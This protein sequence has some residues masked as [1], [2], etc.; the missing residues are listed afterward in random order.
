MKLDQ[1]RYIQTV[2]TRFDIKKTSVKPAATGTKPLSKSNA[3]KTEAE[4]EEMRH[5]SFREVVRDLMWAATMRKSDLSH[6]GQQL[7]K[8]NKNSGPVH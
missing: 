1:H 2:A 8:F 6:T 5:I 3:P 4:V 7:P